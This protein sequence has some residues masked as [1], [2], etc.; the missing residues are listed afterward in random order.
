[1]AVG[2]IHHLPVSLPALRH[3]LAIA[4]VAAG[5][6]LSIPAIAAATSDFPHKPVRILAGFSTGSTVDLSARVVA[7]KLVERLKQQV[8][9]ENRAGA[10]GTIAAQT[11]AK[12]NADGYTLLSVSAA[13]SV[14][15]AIYAHLPYD[16]LK[17]LA[18]ISTTV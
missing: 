9:V 16:T 3:T 18:G 15:P 4:A 13:H 11:V 8:L 10:G 14:A 12:A 5:S 2:N 6:T 7:D 1:M 17:D